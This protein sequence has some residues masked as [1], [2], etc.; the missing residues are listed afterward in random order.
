MSES[1]ATLSIEEV[2]REQLLLD[3]DVANLVGDRILPDVAP[4]NLV[5]PSV[6]YQRLN[7]QENYDIEGVPY[8]QFPRI[9][10]SCLGEG[11]KDSRRV[12]EAVRIAALK[13]RGTFDGVSIDSIFVVDER[14]QG[15]DDITRAYRWDLDLEVYRIQF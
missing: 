6:L 10:Y 13:I 11:W 7:H 14:D 8:M 2:V 4:N 3:T 9:Q 1:A 12:L 5:K 15:V